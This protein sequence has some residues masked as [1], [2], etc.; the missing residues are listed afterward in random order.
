LGVEGF[1]IKGLSV[2]GSWD[3]NM[4]T[5]VY[6]YGLRVQCLYFSAY[7]YLRIKGKQF[8]FQGNLR[9]R[10]EVLTHLEFSGVVFRI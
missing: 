9:I 7:V 10:F 4:V 3:L 5:W 6:M 2:L 8:R 1:R